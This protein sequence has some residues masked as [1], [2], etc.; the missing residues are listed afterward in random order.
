MIVDAHVHVW[1]QDPA[2]YP[3]QPLLSHVPV[4]TYP[5]PVEDLLAEMDAAGVDRAVLV[6][7]SVY[8]WDNSY[9]CDCLARWP[10]RFAG[11]GLVDPRGRDPAGDLARWRERGCQGVRLNLIR[12]GDPAWLAEAGCDAFWRAV[13]ALGQAVSFHMDLEQ[14]GTVAALARRHPAVPFLVDYLGPSVHRG[15]DPGPWL[16]RLAGEA[17]VGFKLLSA[18]EDSRQPYPFPDLMP[19]YA[20]VFRRFGPHRMVFGSDFPGVRFACRYAEA[21]AWPARLPFLSE[22][23]RRT[24]LKETPARYWRFGQLSDK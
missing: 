18:G 2:R 23:D 15:G 7:P 19:F 14:A 13:E 24:I 5:A 17:N 6:Q 12:Q 8:G 11:I 22:A 21:M 16:D 9:L 10:D 3:W 1:A 4:P 20:E